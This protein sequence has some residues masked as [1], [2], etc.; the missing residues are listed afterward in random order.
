MIH[1]LYKII[2]HKLDNRVLA[3][4]VDR[5]FRLGKIIDISA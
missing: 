4:E 5:S 1:M 2:S 3:Y